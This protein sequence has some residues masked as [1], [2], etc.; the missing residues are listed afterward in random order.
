[1]A[2]YLALGFSLARA[3]RV[4]NWQKGGAFV[5]SL[6][7]CYYFFMHLVRTGCVLFTEW[8][9]YSVNCG[10]YRKMATIIL[11]CLSKSSKHGIKKKDF[12]LKQV[13]NQNSSLILAN[14]HANLTLNGDVAP[15][16]KSRLNP[17]RKKRNKW[18]EIIQDH[19]R[20]ICWSAYP[21]TQSLWHGGD[22]I[23]NITLVIPM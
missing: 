17:K 18:A 22:V 20:D 16:S 2:T 7:R 3:A 8:R 6:Y 11:S 14:T 19:V 15:I 21:S 23:P 9:P 5:S 4:R 1:M 10:K 12:H 13:W